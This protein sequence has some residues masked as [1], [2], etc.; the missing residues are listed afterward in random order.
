VKDET[1]EMRLEGLKALAD[2]NQGTMAK[3]TITAEQAEFL[4]ADLH[5]LSPEDRTVSG[6]VLI[7]GQVLYD[8]VH[9]ILDQE[10][11]DPSGR[12]RDARRRPARNVWVRHMP[13]PPLNP[14]TP[15]TPQLSG[16]STTLDMHNAALELDTIRDAQVASRKALSDQLRGTKTQ[17]ES[18]PQRPTH[19]DDRSPE[20][21]PSPLNSSSANRGD[22]GASVAEA[23]PPVSSPKEGRPARK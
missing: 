16:P 14:D 1:Y 21:E 15:G 9:S 17:P 13:V 3:V 11:Q 7:P 18:I 6:G 4:G 23:N 19:A 2:G 20:L 5:D 8:M 10:A 22:T 12:T